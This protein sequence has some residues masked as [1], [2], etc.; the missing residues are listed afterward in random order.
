MNRA[1]L[2]YSVLKDG[3]RHSR[4]DIQQRVGYFLTNNAA[5]ELRAYLKPAGL[6]VVH[7]REGR[8]DFYE[9]SP[10]RDTVG[11]E[12]RADAPATVSR[13][14]SSTAAGRENPALLSR[15]HVYASDPLHSPLPAGDFSPEGFPA[16]LEVHPDQLRIV[17]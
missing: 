4:R 16:P 14:G 7:T 6:D 8:V 12:N 17:A 9:L 13:S 3:G 11:P 1:D 2:L 10:L 15:S 5:S